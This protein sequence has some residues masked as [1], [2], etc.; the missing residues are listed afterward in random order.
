M[1]Y[2]DKSNVLPLFA[3]VQKEE[4]LEHENIY[5]KASAHAKLEHMKL[6]GNNRVIRAVREA[7]EKAIEAEWRLLCA[8]NG[9]DPETTVPGSLP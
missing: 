4:K 8:L 2:M 6:V 5:V 1:V 7:A 9:L 3:K